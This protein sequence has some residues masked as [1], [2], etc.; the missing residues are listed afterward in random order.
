MKWISFFDF[1]MLQT[2]KFVSENCETDFE[3]FSV[4]YMFWSSVWWWNWVAREWGGAESEQAPTG[5]RAR[6]GGRPPRICRRTCRKERREIRSVKRQLTATRLL[7]ATP[8]GLGC[9]NQF[10]PASMA[11]RARMA[12]IHQPDAALKCPRCESANTK[13]C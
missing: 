6:A 13:F 7:M 2:S 4:V 11:D 9:Q 5:A 1:F 8:T 10:C 12:K 3:F